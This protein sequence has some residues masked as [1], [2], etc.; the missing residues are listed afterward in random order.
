MPKVIQFQFINFQKW[1]T[2]IQEKKK[3]WPTQAKES[4]VISLKPEK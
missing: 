2:I 3:D 1:L 4:K